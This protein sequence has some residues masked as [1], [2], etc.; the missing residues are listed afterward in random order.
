MNDYEHHVKPQLARLL[1]AAG[2]DV[3]Y[4]R[5]AGNSLF[6][7]DEHGE[8]VEVLD[9]LGGYGSTILGHHHPAIVARAQQLLAEG[10]PVHA[11]FSLRAR[12]GELAA[13]LSA[14]LQRELSTEE[15][16]IACFANSGAEAIEIAVKHAE[17]DRMLK[18]QD[19]LDEVT[20]NIERVQHAL[21]GG[22]ARVA[23]DI[24]RHAPFREQVFDVR[25]FEDLIV[26]LIDHNAA[27][28]SKR[29]VFLVLERS[30]HG[31]LIGSVQLTHNKNFRR[32][33]QYLGLNTRF[34]A[35]GDVQQLQR[36]VEQEAATIYDLD[37]QGGL[38]RIV[39]RPLPIIAAAL[40]EPIQGEGGVH[41]LDRAFA[42]ALR[43]TC[44]QLACPLIVDEI[45]SG[46]GRCG[47]FLAST[48]LPLKGD[49]VTLSKSLGGGL[50]KISAVL[51]RR[52]RYRRDFSLV[53]SSTFAEDDFSA[54][55]ALQVLD[56]LE[57]DEGRAYGHIRAL[58]NAL[59]GA[60]Q[61]LRERFPEVVR[62]VRGQGLFIGVEF[63]DQRQARSAILRGAAYGD[64]LGYHLAGY[65]L[66]R[67]R[68]RVAPTGSASR[69]L[70]LEPS[71]LLTEADIR[72][73]QQAFED[74]CQLLQAQDALPLV[75]ALAGGPL[76]RSTVQDFRH[77]LPPQQAPASRFA[78]T[79]PV[80]RIAFLNHLIAPQDL[81]GVDP[82]L[83]GLS[84]AQLRDFVLKME[85]AKK[86][87]P[88]EPVRIHSPQGSAVDFALYPLTVCS[89][90]MA[91]YLAHGELDGIR[92]DLED[93]L[94]AAKEDGCELAGLGMYTSIVSNNGC[95]LQVPDIG[96]TTGNALTVA[97][98]LQAVERAAA[99]AGLHLA[100]ETA[101]VVGAAG[102][103]AST[104]A[105]LL[106][107]KTA[108]LILVGSRRDGS[109]R[110]LQQTVH[111]IYDD[112]WREICTLPPAQ[113]GELARRLAEEPLVQA[114]LAGA[115]IP[116]Q[117]HGATIANALCERHG[118]DP[119]LQVTTDR[120]LIREGRIV[121]CAANE[122]EPFLGA[123]D[124]R[125]HAV[126]CDVAVPPNVHA[127]VPAA[128]PDLAYQQGGIVATPNGESLHPS[129]RAF[130][131]EGQL[132]ACMAETV[133]LGLAGFERHYSLGA[134]SKQ[135]VREIAA[136]AALHGFR[137]ADYKRGDSL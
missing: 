52:D 45:Q 64:G 109:L 62:E 41:R 11:Q 53:H 9:L 103:I 61:A 124:F 13:R 128:R 82:S 93:R 135:Q 88:F 68:I 107:E 15:P 8:E 136:L 33:F 26:H 131:A 38:V 43:K 119:Y 92:D 98:A 59:L 1:R 60:L 94:R 30:F 50:A 19:V 58:G 78:S 37:V 48:Q 63:H 31:K 18:L 54:A 86:A 102:N 90:Q 65:L 28:L 81:P 79:R 56:L 115:D 106:A 24:Y 25:H 111:T 55:I 113:L 132:F 130:L 84:P 70:R 16:F 3:S 29:P 97:M 118:H 80:R 105:S 91:G 96:L 69:V 23:P 36:V 116:A 114:W 51:I 85:P 21:R 57:A 14:V 110:R 39:E 100:D 101:V 123:D 10:V 95:A 83:A 35:P 22:R 127:G 122:P 44:H 4:T 32:P 76:P 12:S 67:H 17:F 27:Q 125:A 2:L 5:A 137:L 120:A 6:H 66:R 133:V 47:S 72:R 126:V 40:V 74:V 134:I 46:M 112:A 121:L 34:V 108:R 129:A 104:Y 7:R 87:A 20:L 71:M 75:H 49:I 73:V 77:A 99:E 117:G 89:E 42:Q